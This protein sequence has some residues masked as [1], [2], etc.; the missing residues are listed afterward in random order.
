M[1]HQPAQPQRGT[2]L[3]S[4][5]SGPRGEEGDSFRRR[6]T[7]GDPDPGQA[8]PSVFEGMTTRVQTVSTPERFR[9]DVFQRHRSR[10]RSWRRELLV[11]KGEVTLGRFLHMGRGYSRTAALCHPMGGL[12]ELGVAG[13]FPARGLSYH[14]RASRYLSPRRRK[15]LAGAKWE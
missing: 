12:P 6:L 4:G 5:H 2:S 15:C 8:Y 3:P 10:T 1:G 14:D 11:Q 13:F 9:A 7:F